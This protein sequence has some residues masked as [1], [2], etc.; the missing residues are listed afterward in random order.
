MDWGLMWKYSPLLLNG[1][2]ATILISAA[3]LVLSLALGAVLV[4]AGRSGI[5]PLMV[6]A[7]VYTEIILGIPILV[8][9]YV[10]F[11]VM[12]DLG[13]VIEPL[14]AGLLTLTLY[15]SPYMAEVIRGA[16]NAIP[17]GQIEAARAVGMSGWQIAGRVI[18]PQA[19]GL[20]LPPLTGICIGLVKDSAILSVISVVELAFQT[21]QVVS[22]TYAPFEIYLVVAAMYWVTLSLFENGMRGLERRVTR[23]RTA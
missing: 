3:G 2:E 13:L 22:R 19:L 6:A 4:A 23:Y 7:R 17:G 8:L 12:P 18:L 1:L 16:F 9:L 15:Y 11:F 5:R 14:P 10:I 20:A 21:K